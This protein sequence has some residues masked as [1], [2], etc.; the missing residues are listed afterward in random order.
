MEGPFAPENMPPFMRGEELNQPTLCYR[1]LAWIAQLV[2]K[3]LFDIDVEGAGNIPSGVGYLLAPNHDNEI[4]P[5]FLTYER[6]KHHALIHWLG[7][8]ELFKGGT[9]HLKKMNIRVSEWRATKFMYLVRVIPMTRKKPEIQ[10]VK[11]V[12]RILKNGGVVGIFPE[13]TRV[14]NRADADVRELKQGIANFSLKAN[15]PTVPVRIKSCLPQRHP[16]RRGHVSIIFGHPAKRSTRSWPK[17]PKRWR[18]WAASTDIR[19]PRNGDGSP[20][21]GGPFFFNK[22]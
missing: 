3:Y 5:I 17:R 13:G 16:W 10:A 20:L 2:E 12:L 6:Y 7:K 1:L 15:A 4:D 8:I 9:F 19:P 11:A 21:L 18:N 14:K 22:C